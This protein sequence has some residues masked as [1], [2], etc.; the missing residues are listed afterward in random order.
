MTTD[1]SDAEKMARLGR[2]SALKAARHKAANEAR[3]MATRMLNNI[4]DSAGWKPERLSELFQE[5]QALNL[6]I[7]DNK[8]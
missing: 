8:E 5:I 3:D 2:L 7:E 6:M 1:I 4:D